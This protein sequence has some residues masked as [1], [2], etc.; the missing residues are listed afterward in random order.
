[1]KRLVLLSAFLF[2]TASGFAQNKE[3]GTLEFELYSKSPI[4]FYTASNKKEF[5]DFQNKKAS[6]SDVMKILI[7]LS[8]EGWAVINMTSP[9]NSSVVLR[10]VYLLERKKE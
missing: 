9:A 8:S 6:Y 1:M 10:T 2:F 7:N 5:T 4:S 3:Y